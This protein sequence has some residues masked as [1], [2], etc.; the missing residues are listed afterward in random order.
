MRHQ[1]LLFFITDLYLA[2]KCTLC[3][4]SK[5]FICLSDSNSLS[6]VQKLRSL[7]TCDVFSHAQTFMHDNSKLSLKF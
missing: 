2:L 4:Y 7:K 5:Y 3:T 1:K 6:Y